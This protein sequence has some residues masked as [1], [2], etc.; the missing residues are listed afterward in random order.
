[1]SALRENAPRVV[2]HSTS[3][4]ATMDMLGYQVQLWVLCVL[5]MKRLLRPTPT[6]GDHATSNHD[7]LLA[8]PRN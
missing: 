1:M 3:L 7:R 8:L 2:V 5:G 4:D 6:H